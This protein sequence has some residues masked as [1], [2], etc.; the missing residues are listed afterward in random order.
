[1]EKARTATPTERDLSN[2][3]PSLVVMGILRDDLDDLCVIGDD[4]IL[5]L[6]RHREKMEPFHDIEILGHTAIQEVLSNLPTDRKTAF[7]TAISDMAEHTPS[8]LPE[9]LKD[10][11]SEAQKAV[12]RLHKIRDSLHDALDGVVP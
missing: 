5:A 8:T 1:M 12:C 7:L 11:I 3:P 2:L 10:P 9:N 6:E 4:L